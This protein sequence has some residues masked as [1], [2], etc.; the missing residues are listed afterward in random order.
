MFDTISRSMGYHAF[1]SYSHSADHSLARAIQSALHRIAKPWH[2][3]RALRVFRDETDLAANPKLWPNIRQALDD[4][5]Y[6]VLLASREAGASE[7]VRKEFEYWRANHPIERTI[8]VRTDDPGPAAPL[9]AGF[10]AL[11]GDDPYYVDMQRYRTMESIAYEDPEFRGQVAQISATIRG[12]S[13]NDLVGE[14]AR[15]KS[16]TA[17]VR[18]GAIAALV[19]LLAVAIS[20]AWYATEM[21]DE[22]RLQATEALTQLDESIRVNSIATRERDGF[23]V[24]A[25]AVIDHFAL[26]PD[27]DVDSFL[28]EHADDRRVTL[29][30]HALVA[31][32][33]R[34]EG[35]A[36]IH[37]D[38][39]ES[40][41]NAALQE[42]IRQWLDERS[43]KLAQL[44]DLKAGVA[45]KDAE[46]R[47]LQAVYEEIL[48]VKGGKA[49]RA[50][51]P[52]AK[53]ETDLKLAISVLEAHVE[54]RRQK[55]KND[56]APVE[57]SQHIRKHLSTT[58][59]GQKPTLL[60][61][62]A[63]YHAKTGKVPLAD[64]AYKE[65]LD[66][67]PNDRAILSDAAA[68]YRSTNRPDRAA[69]L[70]VR[71]LAAIRA[72]PPGPAGDR[73]REQIDVMIKL[74]EIDREMHRHEPALAR[75]AEASKLL[76]QRTG[77]PNGDLTNWAVKESFIVDGHLAEVCS[78]LGRYEEAAKH[79]ASEIATM[80]RYAAAGFAERRLIAGEYGSLSW[81]HLFAGRPKLAKQAAITGL[82]LDATE[83]WIRT[84]LAHAFLFEG[85]ISKA[86]E[87]Y[88][89]HA[90]QKLQGKL[91]GDVIS[92]DFDEL[93]AKG[94]TH[95]A[96]PEM[97]TLA[98]GR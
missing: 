71:A 91:W 42:R 4:S 69:A 56:L 76:R 52:E 98:R 68:L 43:A 12:V 73:D 92:A 53:I 82:K 65:A 54:G 35:E 96:M 27:G 79:Q 40:M 25:K 10:G 61:L 26:S 63:R 45:Q 17:R 95:P 23:V 1:I 18:N 50:G 31:R 86:A 85:D 57:A 6:F 88:R 64:A 2:K 44:R 80:E 89:A 49:Q 83:T 87:V 51:R 36:G 38:A 19:L 81:Y 3:V 62:L 5:E 9:P 75:F 93:R 55:T 70:Y 46:I 14:E 37:D 16:R 28:R 8:I 74:G 84:N 20:L 15:Q 90:G 97:L 78:K 41:T 67:A 72:Q 48:K 29:A 77:G 34:S 58:T 59:Q 39:V 21:R 94:L 60:H 30:V 11:F 22:A 24:S 47:L 13:L 66:A 7:W 32:A 33:Y